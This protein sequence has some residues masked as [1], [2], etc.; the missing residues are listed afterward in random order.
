[1]TPAEFTRERKALLK[2][3]LAQI[4]PFFWVSGYVRNPA[5][6][7]RENVPLWVPRNAKGELT[8]KSYSLKGGM[9]I[10]TFEG[11]TDEGVITDGTGGGMVTTYWHGIPIEDLYR[12]NQWAGAHAAQADRLRPP[13]KGNA[14]G[15]KAHRLEGAG[16]RAPV[17]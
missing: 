6:D 11:F 8:L 1:M 5:T 10:D 7:R 9:V 2:A 4:K 12:L 13:G 15:C 3:I 16:A 14:E 17:A